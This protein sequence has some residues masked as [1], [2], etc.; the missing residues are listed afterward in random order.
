MKRR[1]KE[2]GVE[3]IGEGRARMRKEWEKAGRG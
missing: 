3:G 2:W 1:K